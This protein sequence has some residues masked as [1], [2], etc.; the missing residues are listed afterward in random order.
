MQNVT[1]EEDPS[2]F[3]LAFAFLKIYYFR[4]FPFLKQK[5]NKQKLI[6]AI[7]FAVSSSNH[8]TF[9]NLTATKLTEM[10]KNNVYLAEFQKLKLIKHLKT[11]RS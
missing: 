1:K 9:K 7:I 4:L 8:L 2:L 10:N 6:Y 11:T 5:N 3:T